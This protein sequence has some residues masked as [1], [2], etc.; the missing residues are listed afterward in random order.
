MSRLVFV[1]RVGVFGH[2]LVIVAQGVMQAGVLDGHGGDGG[3]GH[4]EAVL[5]GAELALFGGIDADQADDLAAHAQGGGKHGDQTFGLGGFGI[6]EAAVRGGV[7]QVDGLAGQ[8]FAVQAAA[9]HFHGA[10]A[11]VGGGEAVRGAGQQEV[12]GAVQQTDGAGLAVHGLCRVLADLV[13]HVLGIKAG[14][15]G[16]GHITQGAEIILGHG[17]PP[18]DGV[19]PSPA[20]RR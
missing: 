9:F 17:R 6:L 11:H 3:H 7:L 14:I 10:F 1:D 2:Q 16:Q 15:D 13:Q 4:H 20:G 5:V 8:Y 18:L 19:T 12:P